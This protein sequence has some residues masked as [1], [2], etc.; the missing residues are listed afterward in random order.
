MG[1]IQ[2]LPRAPYVAPTRPNGLG[3]S[4]HHDINIP[5]RH[6]KVLTHATTMSSHSPNAMRLI[7]KQISLY[8]GEQGQRLGSMQA[9][10]LAVLHMLAA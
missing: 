8:T 10:H 4:A 1:L 9:V 7:Q 6:A 2:Q 5:G 3:E